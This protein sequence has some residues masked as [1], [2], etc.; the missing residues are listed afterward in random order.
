MFRMK[1]FCKVGTEGFSLYPAIL[2]RSVGNSGIL[3]PSYCHLGVPTR[4]G[5]E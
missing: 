3:F 4:F 2:Y 5:F 1:F